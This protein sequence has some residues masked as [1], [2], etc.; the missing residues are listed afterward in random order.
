MASEALSR[1]I[2]EQSP[3]AIILAGRDGKIQAWN[4]AA[5]RLFGFAA[6]E[7][8]G[9]SLDVIIPE[10]FRRAHWEGF[11]KAIAAGHGKYSNQV[12]TTKSVRKDG[13]AIYVDLSFGL[14]KEADG[15]VIGALAIARDCTQRFA[16][17][18]E[19]RSRVAELE[20]AL[21]A[22]SR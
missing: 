12:L 3:D 9:R 1:A 4:A 20:K 14:L 2:V 19:M 6:G 16:A 5:E 13:T 10:R 21:A 17:D 18:K 22:A 7:V 15:S 8:M 11:D